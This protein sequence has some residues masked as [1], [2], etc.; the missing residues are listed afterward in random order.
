[1]QTKIFVDRRDRGIRSNPSGSLYVPQADSHDTQPSGR[2]D[3]I[4]RL[5]RS[6]FRA[7]HVAHGTRRN[8]SSEEPQ[9]Q[10]VPEVICSVVPDTYVGR[11]H[12]FIGARDWRG[13]FAMFLTTSKQWH[14]K[15]K[16][17]HL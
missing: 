7:A 12:L 2:T 6:S 4:E 11:K 5:L 9:Q 15:N 13:V 1:M 8:D 3:K 16:R 10:V 17:K 14:W